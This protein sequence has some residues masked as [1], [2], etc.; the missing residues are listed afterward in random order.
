MVDLMIRHDDCAPLSSP[1]R[2]DSDRR[3]T[4]PIWQIETD[5]AACRIPLRDS[6]E[7]DVA[8][9]CQPDL[10]RCKALYQR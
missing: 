6:V 8:L 5:H 10:G 4:R 3:R 9:C 2:L 7:V 1:D